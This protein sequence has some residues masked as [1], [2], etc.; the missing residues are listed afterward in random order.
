MNRLRSSN[1]VCVE[2]DSIGLLRRL[3]ASNQ[4]YGA[5][6]FERSADAAWAP[7]PTDSRSP[8]P[9]V[10]FADPARPSRRRRR[11]WATRLRSIPTCCRGL[12]LLM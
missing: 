1:A 10:R 4:H 12:L 7:L 8:S 11:R 3:A 9:P 5:A 6:V 2:N